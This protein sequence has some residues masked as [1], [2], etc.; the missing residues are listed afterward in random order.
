MAIS[1]IFIKKRKLKSIDYILI[2][3]INK[4]YQ[5]AQQNVKIWA[6]T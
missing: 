2:N 5:S 3:R 1:N 4:I 6:Q